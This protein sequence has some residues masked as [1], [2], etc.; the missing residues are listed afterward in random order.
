MYTPHISEEIRPPIILARLTRT[1]YLA[2]PGIK[3]FHILMPN[4]P[5]RLET[6]LFYYYAM[7]LIV[8]FDCFGAF[9]DAG[10]EDMA[11]APLAGMIHDR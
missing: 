11:T 7:L 10:N 8:P 4:R 5:K 3:V 1:R 6:G 2:T 9:L